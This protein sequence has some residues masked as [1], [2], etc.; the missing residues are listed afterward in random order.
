M[1]RRHRGERTDFI[2]NGNSNILFQASNSAPAPDVFVVETSR[3]E[4]AIEKQTYIDVPP[5]LVVEVLSPSEDVS[6]KIG[7]Y[8]DAGVVSIWVVDP[9]RR[10]ALVYG[11]SEKRQYGER[12]KINLPFR[13][14]GSVGIDDIFFGLCAG[15][16]NPA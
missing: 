13:L 9:K 11:G 8:L 4:K 1:R 15:N 10:I 16:C 14:N 12:T 7:I 6:E 3:W 2:A 5:L